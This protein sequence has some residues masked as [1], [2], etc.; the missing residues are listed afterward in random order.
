MTETEISGGHLQRDESGSS[1][2]DRETI[3]F[4]FVGDTIGGSHI[5]AMTLIRGLKG[6][7]FCPLVTVHEAGPLADLMSQEGMAHRALPLPCY[8]G[9]APSIAGHIAAL[10]RTTAPLVRFLRREGV[11]AVHTHDARMHLTWSLPARLAGVKT[12]WH[13]RSKFAPSR[14]SNA[15]M[16][17]ATRIIAISEFVAD[18]LPPQ[19]RRKSIVIYNPFEAPPAL[20]RGHCRA[21]MLAELGAPPDAQVIGVFGNLVDWK[22]PLQFV[23]A[24]GALTGK[25]ATPLRFVVFG[26]DRGGFRMPMEALAREL[27]IADRLIFMGFRHPAWSWLAACDLLLAPAVGEPFGRA[28]VEAMLVGTPVVATDSG[29]HRESLCD[30]DTGLL[31]PPDDASA[32]AEAALHIL[33]DPGLTRDMVT[34]AEESARR[35]FGAAAHA[36]RVTELYEEMLEPA[37]HA[38]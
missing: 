21:Q 7:R 34:R 22:R 18:Q 30:G 37:R 38:A 17:Q 31:V 24:A 10:Y 27:G 33:S 13:A 6:Q 14:L 29:G 1:A 12:I 5:S 4:P 11:A 28:L 20:D 32:M 3:C 25:T 8:L 26:E 9:R 35:R 15:M 2:A 19:A 23:A 16:S 36:K